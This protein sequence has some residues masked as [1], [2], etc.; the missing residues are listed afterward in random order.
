MHGEVKY[1][2]K[3]FRKTALVK[4]SLDMRRQNAMPVVI[5]V[6]DDANGKLFADNVTNCPFADRFLPPM[7]A[8]LVIDQCVIDECVQQNFQVSGIRPT[9]E[10]IDWARKFRK[11]MEFD[12]HPFDPF[13]IQMKD[14]VERPAFS[15]FAALDQHRQDNDSFFPPAAY[16]MNL[17][18]LSP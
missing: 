7:I 3:R 5:N 13:I 1:E 18:R 2:N 4:I 9:H 17:D 15:E 10:C 16:G 12:Q 11:L 8:E 14:P 6:T